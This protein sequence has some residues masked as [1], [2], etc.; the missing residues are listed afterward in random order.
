MGSKR[1]RTVVMRVFLPVIGLAE[2][3]HVHGGR[4]DTD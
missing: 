4:G 1:G 2:G 3:R